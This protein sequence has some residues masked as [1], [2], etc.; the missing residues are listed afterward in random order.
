MKIKQ[1]FCRHRFKYY[2]TRKRTICP[3][4][5]ICT[6][7]RIYKCEKCGKEKEK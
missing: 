7:D 3:Y 1:I 2:E 5:Y 6:W 4:P